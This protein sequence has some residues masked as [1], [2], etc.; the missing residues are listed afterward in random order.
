MFLISKSNCAFVNYRTDA[1]CAA[2]M[3][4]FHDSRFHGVRLV[5]RLRRTPGSPSNGVPVGPAAFI[6][7][8]VQSQTAIESIAQ[9]REVS[10]KAE[11]SAKAGLNMDGELS[12]RRTETYFIMKSLTVE[13][14][15]LSLRNNIW[16]TQAHNEDA[17]NNAFEV[18]LFFMA[19]II[20]SRSSAFRQCILGILSQQI[21]RILWRCPYGV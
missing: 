7:S 1:A 10:S 21:R 5:C 8:A 4:R 6:S 13:D 16:A 20:Y 2:A 17:L 11:E 12:T 9:N 15:E 19:D 3:N 18:S 14:M